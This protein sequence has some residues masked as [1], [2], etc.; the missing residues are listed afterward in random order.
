MATDYYTALGVDR[1][2]SRDEIQ[3]AYRS[4]ARTW[5]PDVNKT[6]GAEDRFKEISE[7]YDVL[8]DPDL[9]KR[10]DAFGDDF[11]QV[12]DDVDPDDW[13]RAQRARSSRGQTGGR[14]QSGPAGDV[15]VDFGD[16]GSAGGPSI[17]DLFG[18]MFNQG[19]P[20]G[21]RPGPDQRVEIDLSVRDAYHGG[22]HKISLTGSGGPRNY[23]VKIPAGVTDGQQIRLAGQG[24]AG[25]GGG[26]AGDLYLVV[27]LV[28]DRR[29]RVDGR[30]ISVDLP[31]SPWEAALGATVPVDTPD[32][33]TKVKIPAGT[34]SGKTL[35]LAGL[36]MPNASGPAG[37]LHAVVK[38]VV[39]DH[40]TDEEQQLFS[41]LASTST[42]DP[43]SPR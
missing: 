12:P 16:I 30:T 11:R 5:H 4:L 37:D 1:S 21:P 22:N 20:A 41:Q 43:R 32:G 35:R 10:Y 25:R 29:F 3:A 42:F 31:I 23:T 24:A 15:F 36:G 38:I 9:R 39:P 27:R 40:L 2:A 34:S 26:P 19:R 14:R 8:S 13:A 6:P 18:G 28:P 17:D 33:D 7:A